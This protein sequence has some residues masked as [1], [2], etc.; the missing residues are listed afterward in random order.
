M[1]LD[2]AKIILLTIIL[3]AAVLRFYK[4]AELPPALEWDEAATAY[5]A[6]SILRT[7]RDQYGN[8]LPLSIRS[9]DDYKP[10]LYTYLTSVSI[11]V[12]GWND[13]AI[14]FPAAF[15]GTLAIFTTYGMTQIL[16][17]RQKLSILVALLLAVS[18]WHVN[19]SRLALETNSTIFF[20]TFGMWAFFK[21]LK[22]GKYLILTAVL[23]GL[24]LYLYHNARVFIPLISTA[25]LVMYWRMLW[26]QKKYALIAAVI[27][28]IFVVRLI[29][30]MTSIEGQMR[31]RG[32][33]IFTESVSLETAKLKNLYTGWRVD[34]TEAGYGWLGQK[35]HSEKVMFSFMLLKNYMLHFNPAFWIFTDDSPRHHV[36][37]LGILYLV[38]LPF[39]YFGL[40]Y[41]LRQKNKKHI[42]LLLLW[43]LF[44]PIPAAVTRD[45]PHSLRTAIF[46]P[47]F[48]ILIGL[49][50]LGAFD[51]LKHRRIKTFLFSGVGILYVLNIALYLHLY[52]M[53]YAKDT[54][55]FW[56]YGRREAA[57]Y[58]ESLKEKYERI[59]VSNR[60]EHPLVFFLYYL[61]YD[62]IKYLREGGTVTGG[63]AET[64]NKFDKYQFRQI[65]YEEQADEK[66][67]F[68][69][70]P[71]EF[72]SDLEPLKKIY[73]LNGQEAIWIIDG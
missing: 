2:R 30:I 4:L 14:R 12:F 59:I 7:G 15:L 22:N 58:A 9:I 43:I 18:P 17:Q 37:S 6:N 10:P 39:V 69:G 26:E 70:L 68:V 64:R 62:P 46:L 44:V 16:F 1:K 36:T 40:Y 53:H 66:T 51:T 57:E 67:L 34:D 5:D 71:G 72:P 28:C 65:I 27:A 25:L 41:L 45:V 56:Q 31:F 19:F 32:T 55:E 11:A 63:W 49:G 13:F 48:Q 29:P 61:K 35:I 50:I 47:T 3:V 33:S 52:Y 8:F 60:M 23:F 73:Y 38:D 20:T 21:G 42:L 54:S 24:D